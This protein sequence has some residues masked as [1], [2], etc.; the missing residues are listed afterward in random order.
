MTFPPP[1]ATVI[2]R[3][4]PFLDWLVDALEVGT[5]HA[6]EYEERY[7]FEYDAHLYAFHVRTSVRNALLRL[8][9]DAPLS[10]AVRALPLCGIEVFNAELKIRVLKASYKLDRESGTYE[11]AVPDARGSRARRDFFYQ[12]AMEL[13]DGALPL[14]AARLLKLVL[15]WDCDRNGRITLLT[16]ALPKRWEEKQN[17]VKLYWRAAVYP[18]AGDIIF[19]V[20]TAVEDVDDPEATLED[21]DDLRPRSDDEEETGTT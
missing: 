11:I 8:G 5:E 6:N 2:A 7:R 10:L 15:L 13:D 16:M 1:P 12:P 20:E 4:R 9:D 18:T 17:R 14:D 3:L 21:F 19:D